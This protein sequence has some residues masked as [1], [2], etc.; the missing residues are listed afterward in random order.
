M[1]RFTI[2]ATQL[3][4]EPGL[5]VQNCNQVVPIWLYWRNGEF[6]VVQVY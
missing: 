3:N 5:L 2:P 1:T 6:D 4:P